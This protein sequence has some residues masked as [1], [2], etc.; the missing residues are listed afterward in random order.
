MKMMLLVLFLLGAA[1]ATPTLD[2]NAFV[3][4]Y[5]QSVDR[6]AFDDPCYMTHNNRLGTTCNTQQCCAGDNGGRCVLSASNRCVMHN[7]RGNNVNVACH[8]CACRKT[9]LRRPAAACLSGVTSRASWLQKV[10]RVWDPNA[11]CFDPCDGCCSGVYNNI[12]D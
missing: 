4:E 6:R 9:S 8:N 12:C 10:V 11:Y 5:L 3:E 2:E 7:M 1:V